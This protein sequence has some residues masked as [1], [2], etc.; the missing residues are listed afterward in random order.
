MG[1]V[2]IYVLTM[3]TLLYSES[4]EIELQKECL[5][6]HQRHQIPDQ[7]IY[8]KYLM[9]YST[10]D[11]MAEAIVKYMHHPDK[12]DSVMHHPFFFKFP[13][14]QKTTLDDQRLKK[15]VQAYLRHFDI[16]KQFISAN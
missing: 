2:I 7:L 8:R 14:K 9:V 10:H 16:K 6:C 3:Y 1:R 11:H 4:I 15:L 12:K 5:S 13:M